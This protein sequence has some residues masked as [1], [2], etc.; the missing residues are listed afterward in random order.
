MLLLVGVGC[1]FVW[2]W[3]FGFDGGFGGEVYVKF[4][5]LFDL[6]FDGDVV[7]EGVDDVL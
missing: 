2:C 7:V 6:C 5:F 1:F 4:G 3:W